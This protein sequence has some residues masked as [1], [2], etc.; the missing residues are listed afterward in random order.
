MHVLK[1]YSMQPTTNLQ[2]LRWLFKHMVTLSL[3]EPSGYFAQHQHFS[4]VGVLKR[5]AGAGPALWVLP[6]WELPIWV[7]PILVI[8]T[9]LS[10]PVAA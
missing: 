4:T 5:V 1:G 2:S 3:T 7:L 8:S 10:V 9:Q 6:K